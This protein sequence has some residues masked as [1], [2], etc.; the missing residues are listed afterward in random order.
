ML[1]HFELTSSIK[2]FSG[3]NHNDLNL[4]AMGFVCT[5]RAKGKLCIYP[6]QI[7]QEQ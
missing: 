3:L 7:T 4:C 2:A 6:P 5:V 1:T